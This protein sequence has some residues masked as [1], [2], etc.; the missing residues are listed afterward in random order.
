[1]ASE[2]PGTVENFAIGYWDFLQAPLQVSVANIEFRSHE[3][4][5]IGQPLMDNLQSSTYEVFERD[6]VKYSKY[7][8]AVYQALCDRP[9][10]SST[11]VLPSMMLL[12]E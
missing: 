9:D 1:M 12:T 8:E 2:T 5:A 7:E 6:P 3:L 10:D 4:K 11:C